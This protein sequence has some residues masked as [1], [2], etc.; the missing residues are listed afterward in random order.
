MSSKKLKI[1]ASFF[2][3]L[4]LLTIIPLN[5]SIP[6]NT[7]TNFNSDQDLNSLQSRSN[8]V[9]VPITINKVKGTAL[10]KEQVEANIKKMNEIYNCEVVIFVWDGTINEI[11]D[12][13]GVADGNLDDDLDDRTTVRNA[14]AKNSNGKGVSITVANDLGDDNTNGITSVGGANSA[15]VKAG[16]E[17]DTW[18]HEIQH[19]LGQS[20]GSAKPADEDING[21]EPGNGE[22]WD[23]NGDGQITNT[24]KDYNLWGRKSD[25]T[26][27]KINYDIIYA[28]AFALAGARPKTRPG[29]TIL[30]KGQNVTQSGVVN[31]TRG[32]PKNRTGQ[33]NPSASHVDIISGGI[34]KNYTGGF[35]T[36][37]VELASS[38][39]QNCTYT[40]AIDNLPH[41]GDN[42]TPNLLDADILI[43]FATTMGFF[44]SSL[45]VWNN[46]SGVWQ[47]LTNLQLYKEQSL[48][49]TI[50]YDNATGSGW[51]NSFFDVILD[52]RAINPFLFNSIEGSFNMWIVAEVSDEVL[53]DFFIDVSDKK[54][55]V[56]QNN[57]VETIGVNNDTVKAGGK[58]LVNGV[59]FTP[60][61]DV[62]IYLDGTNIT[63][64]KTDGSGKF[65]TNITIPIGPSKNSTI[66]MARDAAGKSDAIYINIQG[67]P[68]GGL[69]IIVI[70]IITAAIIATAILVLLLLLKKKR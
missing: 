7:T 44:P 35:I 46:I 59:N 61:S 21:A 3:I 15:L 47:I 65:S 62:T 63:T 66:L 40:F 23:A 64:V 43:Q 10:T 53:V 22:G 60:N 31:E 5:I 4:T 55:L 16:T 67:S 13:D 30:T 18:A 24:D 26:G 25:R 17:G 11:D 33:I 8:Y 20:H 14:A 54:T 39:I 56:L 57:P 12:P 68:A 50:S 27:N 9:V 34:I 58:V 1:L 51:V 70:I 38:P 48:N 41:S 52:A 6:V 2:L 42:V 19:S 28:A 45:S 36:P 32:D 37:W 29:P 69:D 49:E